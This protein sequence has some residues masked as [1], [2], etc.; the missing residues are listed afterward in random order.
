MSVSK[1]Y[2]VSFGIWNN[3][4]KPPQNQQN[5]IKR[6]KIPQIPI[7]NVK[8]E[9]DFN[10]YDY[11]SNATIGY[12]KE[13]FL[14][15]FGHKYDKCCKCLLSLY[16]ADRR[17][18]TLL[19]DDDNTKK[20]SLYKYDKIF[21]IKVNA[22]C[23]CEFKMYNKYMN[24]NKF[25]L[26]S[27]IKELEGL[28]QIVNDN[29]KELEDS[30]KNENLNS[31][32]INTELN[33]KVKKLTEEIKGLNED[34]KKLKKEDEL[35]NFQK[36]YLEENFYDV[37]I[38]INSIT[39]VS[40]EGWNIK[41]NPKILEKFKEEIK[42]K[43]EKE[44]KKEKE[45][46]EK[47]K[48]EENEEQ[49]TITLGV[50]GNNNKGKSFLLSRISQIKLL[51]GTSIETKG[52]SIKYPELKGYK[53][54]QIILLDSAG[55]ETPVLKKSLNE[56][57]KIEEK[58]KNQEN[59]EIK[60]ENPK[61]NEEN[62]KLEGKNNKKKDNSNEKANEEEEFKRNKNFKE[63]ARDKIMTE[64]FLENFIIR[65]SD[66]LLVVVG[67]LTYSEQLLINKIKVESKTQNKGRIFIIHNLQEFREV[68]QVKDY[69][70][71]TLLKCS[72]FN[73][74]KK[75]WISSKKDPEVNKENN[76]K[77]VDEEQKNKNEIKNENEI[78]EENNEVEKNEIKD[79]NNEDIKD[80][81]EQNEIKEDQ[82]DDIKDNN[83]QEKQKNKNLDDLKDVNDENVKEESKLND[84]HFTEIINYGDKKKLEIFHLILAN[85]D[86]E[87][88][89]VYN[90]YAYDFI[91][92]VYNLISEPKKFDIFELIKDNFKNLSNTIFINNIENLNF[93]DEEEILDKKNIKLI[94]KEPLSLKKCFTDE[95]GFSLFKTG[96]FEPKYN[97]F[98]PDPKTLEIRLEVPG[99]TKCTVNHKVEG[100][101]TIITVNGDKNR[102]KTPKDENDNLKDIREFGKFELKIPLPVEQFKI[103]ATKP[104][105]DLAF[106][107][108]LCIIKYEL[109]SDGD[110]VEGKPEEEV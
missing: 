50:L 58:E 44:E 34:I 103:S 21:L 48:Q 27:K 93:T 89:K 41:F 2:M 47:E 17:N 53:G 30:S 59:Q 107:N 98:K 110:E 43:K 4:L 84:V 28:Y 100:D 39:S 10:F 49:N 18:Y 65:N 20:L 104:K 25:D 82:K 55:L 76:E 64:L 67:K 105:E 91:E 52:L 19:L 22:L 51:T 36:H 66:I 11:G 33:E 54:R 31:K 97:Y 101:K 16:S 94:T 61:S 8:I 78:K 29:F 90:Q 83:N 9:E 24:M 35:Q 68:K 70:K 42:K 40:T 1:M 62:S 60:E 45:N 96:N 102:D 95:L 86:S 56:V 32:K 15:T 99:N 77:K 71:N 80:N 13:Y 81:E 106:K 88:G 72:T 26:I 37:V 87:A 3:T 6:E 92:G 108:G 75:T 73:L 69:I 74:K 23:D 109:A 38:D 7:N 79:E 57:E 5:E 12:L 46:K 63:N 85:E 14:T